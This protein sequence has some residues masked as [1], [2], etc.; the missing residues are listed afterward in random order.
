MLLGGPALPILSKAK[1]EIAE[2]LRL[3]LPAL[4]SRNHP[5][6]ATFEAIHVTRSIRLASDQLDGMHLLL[7]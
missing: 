4:L 5:F 1:G 3:Q 7:G 6:L 2:N